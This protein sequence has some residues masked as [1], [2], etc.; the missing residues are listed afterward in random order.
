MYSEEDGKHH[1]K[2]VR[3]LKELRNAL[4]EFRNVERLKLIKPYE[5]LFDLETKR[6]KKENVFTSRYIL[7]SVSVVSASNN[8]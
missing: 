4:E 7:A 6:L 2:F 8:C 3:L 5:K 1:E